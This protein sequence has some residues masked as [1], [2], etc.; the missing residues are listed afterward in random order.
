VNKLKRNLVLTGMMGSGKST[1]GKSLSDQLNLKFVDIDEIIEKKHSLSISQIFETKGEDFFRET[2]EEETLKILNNTNLLVA[3][4]GG[5]FMNKTIR[6][7]IKKSSFS[8]WLDVNI[9]EIFKRTENS[10]KR[11]LLKNIN[12]ENLKKLYDERKKTYSLADF[13]INCDFKTKDE[14]V[15][16]IIKVYEGT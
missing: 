5:A 6:E 4:G 13:K 12:K 1:I 16:E 11:P 2:E 3:L 8:V 14:I 7:N 15:K 10:K 9:N